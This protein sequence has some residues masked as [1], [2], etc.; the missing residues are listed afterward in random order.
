MDVIKTSLIIGIGLTLYY[1]LL[2]WPV[3]NDTYD[4][5][6]QEEIEINTFS[7]SERSLSEPLAPLSQT[8]QEPVGVAAQ[9]SSYFEI[10]N[11]DL[12][13]LVES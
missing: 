4:S 10:Q 3:D 6:F 2:Q 1:L 11:N 12:S 13:L 7:D 8:R 9:E 5:S